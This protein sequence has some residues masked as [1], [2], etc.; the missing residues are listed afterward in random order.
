MGAIKAGAILATMTKEGGA[1]TQPSRRW[2]NMWL[3]SRALIPPLTLRGKYTMTI[4]SRNQLSTPTDLWPQKTSSRLR[5]PRPAE[6]RRATSQSRQ[7]TT[8][9]SSRKRRSLSNSQGRMSKPL[10]RQVASHQSTEQEEI[11]SCSTLRNLTTDRSRGT[12]AA[13]TQDTER[14]TEG[15]SLLV[16]EATTRSR[17]RET[18]I[19]QLPVWHQPLVLTKKY[20]VS[21]LLAVQQPGRG[22]PEDATIPLNPTAPTIAIIKRA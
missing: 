22:I 16:T 6:N 19:V 5:N 10:R 7:L 3:T 21:Q 1:I 15:P 14:G 2:L 13:I 9:W 12:R 18:G 17:G 11:T 4:C 8:V 20:S